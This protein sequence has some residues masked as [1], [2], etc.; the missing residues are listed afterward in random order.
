MP[1]NLNSENAASARSRR[2]LFQ[3]KRCRSLVHTITASRPTSMQQMSRCSLRCITEKTVKPVNVKPVKPMKSTQLWVPYTCVAQ[4]RVHFSVGIVD[5][6]DS[7]SVQVETIR[8]KL[9]PDECKSNLAWKME[10]I[11]EFQ[12]TCRDL[13]DFHKT[14]EDYVACIKH[15]FVC[16]YSAPATGGNDNN[17]D[18]DSVPQNSSV[19]QDAAAIRMLSNSPARGLEARVVQILCAHRQWGVNAILATQAKLNK[20]EVSDHE[21]REKILRARSLQASKRSRVFALKLAQGDASE[22]LMAG[23]R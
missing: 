3:S 22:A 15:L 14:N 16:Q 7:S 18:N 2:R 12:Q 4:R 17:N 10:E 13:V 19:R 20:C 1:S 8:Y 5:D 6:D 21:K 11:K 9:A 23:L